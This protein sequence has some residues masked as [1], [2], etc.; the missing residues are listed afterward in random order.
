MIL[1]PATT[2]SIVRNAFRSSS[3][4]SAV[5]IKSAHLPISIEPVIAA[6]PAIW[7]L[8][9]VAVCKANALET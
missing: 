4:F 7:A 9:S 8:I 5:T 6:I 1:P 3:G 2:I